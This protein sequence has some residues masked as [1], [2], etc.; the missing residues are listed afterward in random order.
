MHVINSL[1][2]S[3]TFTCN[4][5]LITYIY[6]NN[7]AKLHGPMDESQVRFLGDMGR[8]ISECSGDQLELHFYSSGLVISFNVLTPF[9]FM[10]RFLFINNNNKHICIV[11]QG[12]NFRVKETATRSHSSSAVY[13]YVL[14]P[15]S[16]LPGV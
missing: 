6:N 12:R 5:T 11:P 13:I 16:L 4:A 7:Y 2:W 15:G 8:K 9:F 1:R 3:C 14:T 10:K